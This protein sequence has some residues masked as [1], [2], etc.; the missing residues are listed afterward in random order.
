[1]GRADQFGVPKVKHYVLQGPE[2]TTDFSESNYVMNAARA[3][4]AQVVFQEDKAL[5]EAM[6]RYAI[7][8]GYTDLFIIDEEFVKTAIKNEVSRRRGESLPEP[9]RKQE[10]ISVD[11]RLPS[12]SGYVLAYTTAKN[13][14]ALPYSKKYKLFNARDDST[15]AEAK[16]LSIR[17]SCWMPIPEPPKT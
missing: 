8:Q 9:N 15:E 16:G 12:V 6:I 1:M 7:E 5:C 14:I 4:M 10:W 13:Y 11:E 3:I 17:V 2:I